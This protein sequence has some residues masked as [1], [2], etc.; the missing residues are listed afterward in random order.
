MSSRGIS[1]KADITAPATADPQVNQTAEQIK[2]GMSN[3]GAR[4]P[5]QAV[6]AGAKWEIKRPIKTQGITTEQT[7]TYELVSVDG[8]HLNMNFKV[9]QDAANQKMQNPAMKG[10]QVNL[11]KLTTTGSGTSESDLSKLMPTKASMDLHMEMNAEINANN[12]KMPMGMKMDMN[13]SL[14]SH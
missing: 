5:E 8:N 11:I 9:E 3:L 13:M 6:G 1:K 7:E 12:K 2:E 14:E 10:A 4:L